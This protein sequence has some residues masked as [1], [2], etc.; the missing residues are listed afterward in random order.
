MFYIRVWKYIQLRMAL[1]WL[2]QDSKRTVLS[3]LRGET[4]RK[5]LRPCTAYRSGVVIHDNRSKWRLR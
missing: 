2:F 5:H 3:P 1:F 4:T